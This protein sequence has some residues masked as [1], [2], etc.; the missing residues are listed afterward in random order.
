VPLLAQDAM[1]PTGAQCFWP[2]RT[3]VVEVQ[4]SV[5]K[6]GTA[7]KDY[8]YAQNSRDMSSIGV[9]VKPMM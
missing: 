2:S 8:P 4:P 1:F 7:S 6:A 9:S 5:P 3:F